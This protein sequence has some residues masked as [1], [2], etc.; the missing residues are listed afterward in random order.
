M[1]INYPSITQ[2]EHHVELKDYRQPTKKEYIRYV[3]KLAE[4]FQ[5]DPATLTEDQLRQY[6]LFLHQHKHY[7]AAND[8]LPG[9]ALPVLPKTDATAGTLA[10][11][12]AVTMSAS[13]THQHQITRPIRKRLVRERSCFA[14]AQKRGPRTGY[15]AYKK[16][17]AFHHRLLV[18]SPAMFSAR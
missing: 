14:P 3:R 15:L 1:I 13:H 6:F 12:T 11:T 2:F 10:A 18:L 4:H 17:A 5:C 16:R 7:K 9:P 8:P